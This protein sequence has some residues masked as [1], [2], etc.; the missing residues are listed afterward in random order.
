M[1]LNKKIEGKF[2][3]QKKLTEKENELSSFKSKNV[4]FYQTYLQPI[5]QNF[6]DDKKWIF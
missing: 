6:L 5:F 2:V 3:F 4:F 1:D